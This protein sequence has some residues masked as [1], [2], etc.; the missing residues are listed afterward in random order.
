MWR[1]PRDCQQVLAA[2]R[3][4]RET[5]VGPK[6]VRDLC[7]PSA[8]RE[9]RRRPVL[10]RQNVEA[11]DPFNLVLGRVCEPYEEI[12]VSYLPVA[13]RGLDAVRQSGPLRDL[14][15][16]VAVTDRQLHRLEPL[17]LDGPPQRNVYSRAHAVADAFR[18]V[19]RG[20]DA[21][22]AVF[23]SPVVETDPSVGSVR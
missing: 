7:Q 10:G 15:P 17:L 12:G 4:A 13:V 20:S 22:V 16:T 2:G 14:S 9:Q 18:S 8:R 5:Y 21:V 6:A 1:K 23:Q 19:V 11:G 3:A